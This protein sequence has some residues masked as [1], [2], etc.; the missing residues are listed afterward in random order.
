MGFLVKEN[1]ELLINSK[2]QE[3]GHRQAISAFSLDSMENK[4]V[5]VDQVTFPEMTNA[6]TAIAVTPADW[7]LLRHL[8]T[9]DPHL[10]SCH[11]PDMT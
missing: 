6:G 3:I 7:P 1:S 11:G 9:A 4:S 2:W 5:G 8:I 10:A